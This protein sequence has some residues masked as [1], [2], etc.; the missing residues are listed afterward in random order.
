MKQAL[1][2]LRV[3]CG[4]LRRVYNLVGS[5][6]AAVAPTRSTTDHSRL[7]AVVQISKS[8]DCVRRDRSFRLRGKSVGRA[9]G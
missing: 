5:Q 6:R 7:T 8:G 2:L 1:G 9:K 4:A 3:Q